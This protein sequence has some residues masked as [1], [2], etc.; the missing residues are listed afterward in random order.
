MQ[1]IPEPSQNR[2]LC[3]PSDELYPKQDTKHTWPVRLQS[4][5]PSPT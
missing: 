2:D 4:E 3:E 5:N 1:G